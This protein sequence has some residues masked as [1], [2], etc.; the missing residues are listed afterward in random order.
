MSIRDFFTSN[1][2]TGNKP[3]QP[4]KT[5]VQIAATEAYITFREEEEVSDKFS[6]GGWF[7]IKRIKGE[8]NYVSCNWNIFT[9]ISEEVKD[10]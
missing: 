1:K 8:N 2:G 4:S 10:S 7:E 3:S 9:F 5:S 6:F